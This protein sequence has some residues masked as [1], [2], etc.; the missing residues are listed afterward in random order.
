MMK[1]PGTVGAVLRC[2]HPNAIGIPNRTGHS[3]VHTTMKVKQA[4][5]LTT[6]PGIA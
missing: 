1:N 3:P 2:T 6:D 4:V 5:K